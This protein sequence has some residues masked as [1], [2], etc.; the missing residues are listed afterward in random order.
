LSEHRPPFGAVELPG[1]LPETDPRLVEAM[2][3]ERMREV[4]MRELTA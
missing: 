4:R 1:V 2:A 3:T